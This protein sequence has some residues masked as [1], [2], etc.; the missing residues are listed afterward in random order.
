[1]DQTVLQWASPVHSGAPPWCRT[2]WGA[3]EQH[4]PASMVRQLIERCGNSAAC[5]L[6]GWVALQPQFRY[7][8]RRCVLQCTAGPSGTMTSWNVLNSSVV[9]IPCE[10]ALR[11]L[12]CLRQHTYGG[13]SEDNFTDTKV[14]C[15]LLSFA[16]TAK[17]VAG[18][19]Q[20]NG[21]L[22]F[23]LWN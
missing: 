6:Y 2:A 8:L 16:N 5:L 18:W 15:M 23:P 20:S 12:H 11:T 10:P 22:H 4:K 13:T 17:K 19:D 7:D 9:C 1:M 14:F 21:W 3:R